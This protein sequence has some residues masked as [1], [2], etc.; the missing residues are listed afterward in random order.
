MKRL[1]EDKKWMKL[2]LSLAARGRGKVS[3][4]PCVGAVVV[5]GGRS[6]GRGYHAKFGGPHAEVVALQRAGRRARGATLYVTLEPCSTY[7]KTPPCTDA[8]L[9]SGVRRVVVG[10][11][12]PNPQ[13]QGRGIEILRWRGIKVDVG[14]EKEAAEEL[15]KAFRR[16]ITRKVPYVIVKEAM[17]LDGKIATRTG[18]SRWV[19][20][21]QARRWAH[22][23]RSRV[24]AI[25]VGK[26]TALCD[27]PRLTA[28]GSNGNKH[29]PLRLI[30]SS[31]RKFPRSLKLFSDRFKNK[32][33]IVGKR[34]GTIFSLI[35][36][37]G[38]RGITSL[39]V[40]GGG[41]TAARFIQAKA[42]DKLYFVVA[43]KIVGG[44]EAVTAVEGRGL[45]RMASALTI[46]KWQWRS[47][48][49]DI[50]IEAQL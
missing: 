6:V 48:G 14:V 32:T 30:L 33:H 7:G 23:L 4:N 1:S 5:R 43:P 21:P 15:I 45:A 18:D 16:W 11:L 22:Q 29:Q 50:L 19:S 37:L 20:G 2:A 3:P 13:H 49:K 39:L 44:R 10:T 47:L 36:Q 12:D 8:I 35:K 25:L 41:E 28:R 17:T 31:T 27:N 34:N 42:V 46:K 40:E 24:D 26:R 38:K 9:Q